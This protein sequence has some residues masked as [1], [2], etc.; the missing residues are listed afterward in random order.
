MSHTGKR[1]VATTS[2][3][4]SRSPVVIPLK[5]PRVTLQTYQGT[6]LLVPRKHLDVYTW[7]VSHPNCSSQ[8]SFLFIPIPHTLW[9]V[10]L[11]WKPGDKISVCSAALD[12]L[13]VFLRMYSLIYVS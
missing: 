6:V 11:V 7:A 2:L 5:L 8:S 12:I 10:L 1:E 3:D 4:G 9:I 13:F